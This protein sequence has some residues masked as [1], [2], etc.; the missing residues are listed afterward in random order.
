[1]PLS[2]QVDSDKPDLNQNYT[3]KAM[4]LFKEIALIRRCKW[5]SLQSA[6]YNQS[7]IR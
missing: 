5:I 7:L 1:M 2:L 4:S 3:Q 6:E